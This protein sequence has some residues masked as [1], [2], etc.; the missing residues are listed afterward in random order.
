MK[1]PPLILIVEDDEDDRYL[2]QDAFAEAQLSCNFVFAV[3]G[4]DALAYLKKAVEPPALMLLDINMPKLNGFEVLQ[5]LRQ[6]PVWK[7]LPVVMFSTSTETSTITRAYQSGVNSYVLKPQ[8]FTGLVT[9]LSQICNY[10]FDTVRIPYH[11]D[12]VSRH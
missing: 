11:T 7:A 10:W 8:T 1:T 12:S 6:D 3:D 5:K 4:A 2:I 9:L